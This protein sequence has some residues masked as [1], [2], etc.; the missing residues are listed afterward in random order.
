MGG[1]TLHDSP[2]RLRVKNGSIKDV[3][4]IRMP[5]GKVVFAT[6]LFCP[7]YHTVQTH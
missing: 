5:A 6:R 7:G 1:E 4:I 2:T 3:V